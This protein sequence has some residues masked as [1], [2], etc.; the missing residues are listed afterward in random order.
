[1]GDQAANN[2]D[3]NTGRVAPHDSHKEPT[4]ISPIYHKAFP[5]V[6]TNVTAFVDLLQQPILDT[7]YRDG[8]IEGLL[9]EIQKRRKPRFP[10][11][12]RIALIGDMAA[13]RWTLTRFVLARC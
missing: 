9:K 8:N 3:N 10:E 1:M 12:V 5:E 2:K 6:K 7:H 4:P 13:G 11:E